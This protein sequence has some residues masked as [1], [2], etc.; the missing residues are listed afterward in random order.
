LENDTRHKAAVAALED[1]FALGGRVFWRDLTPRLIG[2]I[3]KRGTPI[4][5]GTNG[6]YLYQCARETAAG[7][8]DI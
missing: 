5:S 4:L 1:Y 2:E 7:P 6:T 3:V 8:D